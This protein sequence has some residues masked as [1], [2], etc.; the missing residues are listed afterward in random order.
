[1]RLSFADGRRHRVLIPAT[2]KAVAERAA[3][4]IRAAVKEGATF[5]A[6]QRAAA[7]LAVSQNAFDESIR[8]TKAV[9]R[10]RATQD[11]EA[12]SRSDVGASGG[13]V[14]ERRAGA[15]VP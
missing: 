9:G 2:S 3:K 12:R 1:M 4:A 14:D 11:P 15:A 6:V 5:E 8:Q 10:G 7:A 13:D